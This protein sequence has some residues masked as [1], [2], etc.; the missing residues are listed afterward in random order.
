MVRNY[1]HFIFLFFSLVYLISL[2]VAPM[3]FGEI[4]LCVCCDFESHAYF[5]EILC[6]EYLDLYVEQ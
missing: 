3:C 6:N 2:R 1:Y 5:R 4:K